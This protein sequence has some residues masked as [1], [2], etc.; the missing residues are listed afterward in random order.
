VEYDLELPD[1]PHG[2]RAVRVTYAPEFDASGR[3]VGWVAAIVYI[4]ERKQAEDRLAQLAAIVESSD[5]AIISNTLEG[6]ITSWNGGAAR[7]FG[8]DANEMIGEPITKIIPPELHG[9]EEQILARLERGERIEHFQA[10]G[11]AKDG[12]RTD[13]SLKVSP[14]YDKA[15]KVIGVSK[16]ARDITERKRTERALAERNAQLLLAG[17]GA[18]VGSYALDITAR[19]I[20]ISPGY[21][22]TFE[23]PAGSSEISWDDWR[24]RVHPEDLPQL[25][26]RRGKSFAERK[27][28]HRAE[29]RIVRPDGQVR[30]IESRSLVAYDEQG[31][32]QRTVGVKIDITER[33]QAEQALA[34]SEERLRFVAERANVGHWDW[35]IPSRRL[36]F[37]TTFRRLFGI[38]DEEPMSYDRFLAA[39]H[40]QDRRRADEIIKAYLECDGNTDC[41]IEC[42]TLRPDGTVRWIL[43]KGSAVFE[44]GH[45]I[46]MAGI[47][48][49]IT[50]R[51]RAEDHLR[52]VMKELSHRTKN[53]MAVVHAISWQTAQKSVDL[54]DFEQRFIQRL[55]AL[56]RSHDLLVKHDWQGVRLGDLVQ[57][58]LDPF[59][60]SFTGRLTAEGPPLLLRPSA[61]QELGLALHELATNASKYGALSVP[62]G[63]IDI[64]WAI[65]C[66]PTNGANRF[67]MIWCETG[68]PGVRPPV[69]KGFGTAVVTTALSTT[70]NGE[71]ELD[72]RPEGLCWELRAPVGG[73]IQELDLPQ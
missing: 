23:F 72:Y 66:G 19:R 6:R 20:Q 62:T 25:D 64:D 15:G 24:A 35:D 30:W 57:A 12:R 26:Q 41:D 61:A 44:A 11:V 60:D 50:E 73:L 17:T 3:A 18:Q 42:R 59:L 22:A 29:Y 69:S 55:E 67:H 14:V 31:H 45:A 56:A 49:D 47:V 37:S 53:L 9:E 63:K 36:E 65:D 27:A 38:P 71:A 13:I 51:K 39:V 40:P 7:I 43:A 2:P 10:I 48:L 21:A 32:P 16:V 8:Y 54:E 5:D 68:G 1:T 33:K 4:T 70:F 52:Y 34:A 46:R 58:Q 28:E